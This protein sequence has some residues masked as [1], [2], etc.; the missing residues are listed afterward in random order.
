MG[1]IAGVL[2]LG[3]IGNQFGKFFGLAASI[4]FACLH[5][6][7]YLLS[8]IMKLTILI[9]ISNFLNGFFHAS[10]IS[11]TFLYME[12]LLSIDSSKY[13]I[14]ILYLVG[15]GIGYSLAALLNMVLPGWETF[16]IITAVIYTVCL[17]IFIH[18]FHEDPLF[19]L[20]AGRIKEL[21]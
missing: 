7:L 1:S 4:M 14:N 10:I 18:F 2:F 6:Y 12:K 9:G 11:L 16:G 17:V 15:A 8:G 19:L 21:Y 20:R 5:S 3:W 13:T